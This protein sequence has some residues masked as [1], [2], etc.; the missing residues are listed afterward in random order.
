MSEGRARPCPLAD[1]GSR[2]QHGGLSR[3]RRRDVGV[4]LINGRGRKARRSLFKGAEEENSGTKAAASVV[5]RPG[6]MLMRISTFTAIPAWPCPG[7]TYEPTPF[8]QER[9]LLFMPRFQ[10]APTTL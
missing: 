8:P 6:S 10:G 4:R 9:L 5:V 1:A 3:L 2:Q 7:S